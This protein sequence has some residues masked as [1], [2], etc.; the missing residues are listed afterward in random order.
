MDAIE[1]YNKYLSLNPAAEDKEKVSS[2]VESLNKELLK[3]SGD[4]EPAE[5]KD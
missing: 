4:S 3:Y 2:D 5:N 1:N